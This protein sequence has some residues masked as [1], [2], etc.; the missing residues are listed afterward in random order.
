MQL[1]KLVSKSQGGEAWKFGGEASP[2]SPPPPPPL[3][4]TL[5]MYYIIMY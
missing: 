4:E 1:I 3:D 5:I 2:L